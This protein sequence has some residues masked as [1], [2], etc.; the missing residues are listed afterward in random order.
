MNATRPYWWWVNIGSGNGLV[1]SDNKPLPE[2]MLTQGSLS[3]YGV[4]RPQWVD[5][6]HLIFLWFLQGLMCSIAELLKVIIFVAMSKITT[7][8]IW[9]ETSNFSKG[10]ASFIEFYIY[11]YFLCLWPVDSYWKTRNFFICI[12]LNSNVFLKKSNIW[13][14]HLIILGLGKAGMPCNLCILLF[15]QDKCKLHCC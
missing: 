11:I 10:P 6:D 3:P 14:F 8:L 2:P 7:C 12:R 1:P 13:I 9:S 15:C 4:T 5:L